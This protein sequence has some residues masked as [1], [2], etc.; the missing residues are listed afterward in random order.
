MPNLFLVGAPKCGTT[1]IV[2]WLSQTEQ[3]FVPRGREP[4]YFASDMFPDRVC[5]TLQRYKALYSDSTNFTYR[6]DGSTGYLASSTAVTQILEMNPSA[7]FIAMVRDPADMVL[8]LHR[9]RVN[10]GRETILSAREAWDKSITP[11]TPPVEM[12]LNYRLQCDLAC[13]LKRIVSQVDQSS[14]LILSLGE[15]ASAPEQTCDVIMDFLGLPT[16]DNP[17]FD[18]Q[19]AAISRRSLGFQSMVFRVK[20]IRAK[21]GIPAVG[22]GFFKSL[23]KW[24]TIP[25][26]AYLED[27]IFLRELRVECAEARNEL[28]LLLKNRHRS[29]LDSPL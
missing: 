6:L 10:E 8:S 11:Q 26:K 29:V 20:T 15:V 17:N 14:L 5:N 25:K 18:V 27:D 24:N 1:S 16:L 19:G 3:V 12:A 28:M 4:H 13:Q 21:M 2:S 23:E 7:K 22:W 9:E